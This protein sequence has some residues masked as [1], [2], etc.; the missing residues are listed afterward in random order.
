MPRRESERCGL[1]YY[2]HGDATIGGSLAACPP[3]GY[4]GFLIL[5]A[6][7]PLR[8]CVLAE[9]IKADQECRW[10]LGIPT[11]IEDY[12]RDWP[13][14]PGQESVILELLVGECLTRAMFVA[15]PTY[16][17]LRSRFPDLAEHIDLSQIAAIVRDGGYATHRREFAAA[18]KPPLMVKVGCAIGKETR[19]AFLEDPSGLLLA[20]EGRKMSDESADQGGQRSELRS[21]LIAEVCS[22]FETAWQTS[23]PPRIEEFL[24]PESPDM[25]GATLRDLLRNW[26]ASTSNGVGRQPTCPHPLRLSRK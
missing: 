16:Q 3:T 6:D 17:E 13:D 8:L 25:T 24:P 5:R 1:G 20:V 12:L 7:N 21:E 4:I 11:K 10:K 9:L 22:R 19:W 23:Q 14:L 15:M 2:R 26:L 18:T